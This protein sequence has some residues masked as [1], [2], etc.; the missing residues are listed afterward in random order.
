MPGTAHGLA[1]CV[2]A[3]HPQHHAAELRAHEIQHPTRAV[4]QPGQGLGAWQQAGGAAGGQQGETAL[5]QAHFQRGAEHHPVGHL[6]VRGEQLQVRD[7]AQRT[8]AWRQMQKLHRLGL[9]PAA[10]GL[11][12]AL[13][14]DRNGQAAVAQ[15]GGQGGF[16]ARGGLGGGNTNVDGVEALPA[17]AQVLDHRR[18]QCGHRAGAADGGAPGRGK[19][20]MQ[21]CGEVTHKAA[22]IGQV[23]VV[24]LRCGGGLRHGIGLLL[25]RACRVDDKADAVVAQPLRK[26]GGA[27][28]HRQPLGAMAQRVGQRLGLLGTA[29]THHQLDGGVACQGAADAGAEVAVAA[30]YQ[31]FQINPASAL[32]SRPP[33]PA[34][35][36]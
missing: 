22:A 26:A 30:E 5:R 16:A 32:Q 19:G 13:R 31:C 17:S 21:G 14:P 1:L 29:A 7:V 8:P 25:E 2:D 18:R 6:V 9:R 11:P 4:Q 24:G 28:V 33:S 3:A 35:R 36:A 27:V 34:P 12:A 15:H 23:D 20:G 10:Q